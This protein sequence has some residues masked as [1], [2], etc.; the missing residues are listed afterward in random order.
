[1][2][3]L[4]RR[5]KADVDAMVDEEFLKLRSAILEEIQG[6]RREAK[7]IEERSVFAAEKLFQMEGKIAA[8]EATNHKVS[9]VPT[10]ALKALKAEEVEQMNVPETVRDT[11]RE[12]VD[13]QERIQGF[14][15]LENF[16]EIS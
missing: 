13:L 12:I 11:L 10:D 2:G 9:Y 16:D 15:D 4:L 7:L 1:M 3:W 5:I 14:Q 6:L 8:L